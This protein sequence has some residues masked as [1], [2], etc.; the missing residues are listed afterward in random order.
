MNIRFL[1]V[2]T[3]L[4]ACSSNGQ[5]VTK[6]LQISPEKL[7]EIRSNPYTGGNGP[8]GFSAA[9][10]AVAEDGNGPQ[11]IA[12]TGFGPWLHEMGFTPN[13]MITAIDGR[14]VHEI[15]TDRWMAL[16]LQAPDAFDAA[17]YKDFIEYLFSSE[18][19]T[20]VAIGLH[21]ERSPADLVAGTTPEKS[22]VWRIDFL[23]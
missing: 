2:I 13:M 10:L 16:R 1:I 5:E 15:F 6:T 23:R 11:G 20:S 4:T 22:Q 7:A 3:F 12:F 9:A 21:V 18:P 19:G 17:H 14:N 8:G